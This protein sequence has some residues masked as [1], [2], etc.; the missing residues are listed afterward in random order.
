MV[1]AV[2]MCTASVVSMGAGAI[3][4]FRDREV[5]QDTISFYSDDV[6][7][8]FWQAG[9]DFYG[10]PDSLRVFLSEPYNIIDS[11]GKEVTR[12]STIFLR[13]YMIKDL[14]GNEFIFNDLADGNYAW[15][16]STFVSEDGSVN[17]DKMPLIEEY[18]LKNSIPYTFKH[19][20]LSSERYM[21][22]IKIDNSD[23]TIDETAQLATDVRKAVGWSFEDMLLPSSMVK[24]EATDIE[25]AL[26][27]PTL[28][29]DANEDDKVSLA[30]AVLIMQALSN[31]D[32][33]KITPQGMANA[34][35]DGDGLTPTDAAKIQQIVLNS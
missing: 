2:A 15:G 8:T 30:D 27:E 12:Q 4:V 23:R 29:G 31:P 9:T 28:S 7:Y 5:T 14:D 35:I 22:V 33:Y 13:S 10:M 20:D 16:I 18:L 19:I 1:S 24:I 11:T 6:K 17:E 25:N 32:E 21:K 34:D 3:A 26:P